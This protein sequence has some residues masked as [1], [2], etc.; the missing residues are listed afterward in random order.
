MLYADLSLLH[1]KN[2]HL[3]HTSALPESALAELSKCLVVYDSTATVANLQIELR[4]L[5]QQWDR[6][7]QSPLDD[8]STRAVE[9]NRSDDEEEMDITSKT[10]VSCKECPVCCYKILLRF[11]MMTHAYPLLGLAYK[12]LLT[13]S[14]T[15][16]ACE[17]SFST[18]RY[19]KNRLR[20]C[21]SAS[22]L[23]AFML[24]ATEKDVLVSLDTDTVID[25]I[26]ERSELLKKLLL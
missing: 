10:C 12:F 24:M 20:S 16:V 3:I 13:L 15:Q 18:L 5:A 25:R 23:E 2:F 4:N 22:K 19:I 8:Y 1:P 26:A 11:N 21:L 7:V 17:R 14:I 9:E 6:L